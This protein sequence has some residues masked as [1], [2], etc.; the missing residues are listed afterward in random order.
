MGTS[1]SIFLS[2]LAIGSFIGV[3]AHRFS[4]TAKAKILKK[5]LHKVMTEIAEHTE[6][7]A[8]TAKEKMLDASRRTAE[9]FA[10]LTFNVAEKADILKGRVHTAV[11]EAKK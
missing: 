3:L 4:R 5:R 11:S 10:D 9:K 7:A 1:N 2:G 6:E 8:E